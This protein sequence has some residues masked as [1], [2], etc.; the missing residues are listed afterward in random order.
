MG[1]IG[2]AI[3]FQFAVEHE[4]LLGR[5]EPMTAAHAEAGR[6]PEDSRSGAVAVIERENFHL[7][8]GPRQ[9]RQR[10]IPGQVLCRD[11]FDMRPTHG[12]PLSAIRPPC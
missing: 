7:D 4:E 2:T 8:T 3:H 10:M 5:I 9:P 1:A 11:E 12:T 6:V